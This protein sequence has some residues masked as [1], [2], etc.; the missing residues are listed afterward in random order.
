MSR[1]PEAARSNTRTSIPIGPASIS[2]SEMVA[3]T[4][5]NF[6]VQFGSGGGTRTI[7]QV[8]LRSVRG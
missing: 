7:G 5:P 1:G 2:F 8:M 3:N 4:S 6:A